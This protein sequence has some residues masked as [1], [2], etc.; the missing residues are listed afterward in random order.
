MDVSERYFTNDEVSAIVRQGLRQQVASGQN[1]ISY[2]E[3]AE[4]AQQVGISESALRYAIE[5]EDAVGEFERAKD[6]WL[7][8]RKTSFFHHLRT[9]C[10]VNGFL[11]LLNV[12]TNPGGYLW[13]AW[14][15]LGWGIALT[16]RASDTFFPSDHRLERGAQRLLRQRKRRD[17]RPYSPQ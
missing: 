11:F 3:L 16:F 12:M 7:A 4:V 14:P 9:Y 6:D 13:V 2:E 1:T 17:T 15:L 5:I 10:I 8:H